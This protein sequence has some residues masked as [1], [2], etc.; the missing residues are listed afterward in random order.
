[1][2]PLKLILGALVA[3]SRFSRRREVKIKMYVVKNKKIFCSPLEERKEKKM[4]DKIKI[5]SMGIKIELE[6]LLS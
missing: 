1:M 3:F 2:G 4:K 5:E 6:Y